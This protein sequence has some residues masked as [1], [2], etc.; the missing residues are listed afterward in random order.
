MLMS[1]LQ[2]TGQNYYIKVA[3]KFF[4][5]VTKCKHLAAMATNQNCIRQE[6]KSRQIKGNACFHAL[7]NILSSCLLSK[8][9]K[10]NCKRVC[11]FVWV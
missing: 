9:R 10:A 8:K 2:T 1:D 4:E 11:S 6:I 7:Q 3:N 5:N